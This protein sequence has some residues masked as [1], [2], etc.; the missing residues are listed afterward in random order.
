MQ[1]LWLSL[2]LPI[3]ISGTSRLPVIT[4]SPET[5]LVQ[6]DKEAKFFC[7]IRSS[8]NTYGIYWFRQVAPPSTDSRYQFLVHSDKTTFTHG[9]GIDS[10]HVLVSGEASKSTLRILDV[11][12]SDGGVYICAIIVGPQLVFGSGT[13]LNVVDVL[14]TTPT[15]TKKTTPKRRVCNTTPKVTQQN[16]SLCSAFTLSL[17]VGCAVILLISIIVIIRLNYL[18][19]VARHHFVKQL[20]R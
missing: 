5:L 9:E 13:W 2:F 7:D 8:A 14:P 16:G 15:P 20:Q 11:K 3:Q 10:E 4:Q 6:T 12:P 1:L 19:N 18:W 17:L